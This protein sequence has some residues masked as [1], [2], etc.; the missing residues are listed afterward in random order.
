M[1]LINIVAIITTLFIF[2]AGSAFGA[3]PIA[4]GGSITVPAGQPD[5]GLILAP[6]SKGVLGNVLAGGDR[7]AIVLKHI[8]GTREFATSSAGTLIYYNDVDPVNQDTPNMGLTL[9]SSDS[10]DFAAWEPLL[11]RGHH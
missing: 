4:D 2:I 5:A 11:L 7:Y 10:S 9:S 3:T 6:M 1:L 8:H